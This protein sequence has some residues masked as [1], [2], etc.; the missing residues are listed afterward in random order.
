LDLHGAKQTIAMLDRDPGEIVEKTLTH[1]GEAVREFNASIPAPALSCASS[2]HIRRQG[3]LTT[4]SDPGTRLC[5]DALART[6]HGKTLG[7]FG[8]Q[9]PVQL[10]G[11]SRRP[12]IDWPQRGLDAHP[13]GQRQSTGTLRIG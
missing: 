1:D 11:T 6:A 13:T 4:D 2:R 5:I 10:I 8:R 3:S 9:R 12:P 7:E